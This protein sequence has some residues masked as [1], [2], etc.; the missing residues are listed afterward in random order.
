MATINGGT[1]G[2]A[3][4]LP[5]GYTALDQSGGSSGGGGGPT[6]PTGTDNGSNPITVNQPSGLTVGEDTIVGHEADPSQPVYLSWHGNGA[7]PTVGDNDVV[8]VEHKKP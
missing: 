1:N 2:F 6:G 3:E 8:R 7:A 4:R 5:A